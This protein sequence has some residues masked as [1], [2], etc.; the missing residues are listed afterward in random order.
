MNLEATVQILRDRLK[1]TQKAIIVGPCALERSLEHETGVMLIIDGGLHHCQPKPAHALLIGDGDS[2]PAQTP[3]EMF[4]LRLP[5]KKDR[6]DL[7]WGLGLLPQGVLQCEFVGFRGGRFDHEMIVLGEIHHFL[8]TQSQCRVKLGQDIKG[9]GAGAHHIELKG[10]FSILSLETI[11]LSLEGEV[12][13]E[14]RNLTLSPFSSHAL[15]NHGNGMVMIQADAP[16]F[17]YSVPSCP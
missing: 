9:F 14:A 15:S 8:K 6:S 2:C 13:Y 3:P 12:E 17:I 5:Q 16:F 10:L 7:S 1:T 4:D 11:H